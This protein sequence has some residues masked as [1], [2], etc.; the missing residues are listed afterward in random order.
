MALFIA[1]KAFSEDNPFSNLEE[2]S[3]LSPTFLAVFLM[4]PPLNT[5]DSNTTV[6]VSFSI[7][8]FN[9][10]I[11]PAIATAFSSSAI[12]KSLL[13]S[14]LSCSSNVVIF[15]PSFALLIVIC[16]PL[17]D[18]ISKACIGCPISSIT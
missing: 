11:T 15:S 10:P 9:P 17:I 8:E 14:F 1:L 4:L 3:V 6:D 7:S 2:L 5:A 12:T 18:S 16:F 13:S